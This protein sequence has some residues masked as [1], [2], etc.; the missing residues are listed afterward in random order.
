MSFMKFPPHSTEQHP[1]AMRR[2]GFTLIELLVVIAI[3]ALLIGLLLPAIQ[4]VRAAAARMSCSNNLKQLGLGLHNFETAT[5]ALPTAFPAN[6]PAPYET[7]PPYYHTW[8]SLAQILPYLEQTN[9]SN[10]LNLNLP[11]YNPADFTIFP[12]NRDAVGMKVRLFLC[13]ADREQSL[14]GGYGVT[15]FGTT[16]Y[17]ACL[18]SGVANGVAALGSPWDADGMFR[19]RDRVK[20]GEI[21]DGLSNTAAMSESTL[22]EG[23]DGVNGAMPADAWKVFAYVSIG[24]PLSESACAEAH[25]WNYT[26]R[27]GFM[28][29]SGEIR[30]ASYN[31]Y[32]RPNDATYDCVTNS[33]V[34]GPQ[35][36]TAIGF[37][38]ARS[39]HTGVVN[40]LFGD[41]SV[42]SIRDSITLETWRA[43]ATRGGKEVFSEE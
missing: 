11:M 13:P 5:G 29:A 23:A 19:A 40:V 22:G 27:R 12:E 10:G 43:M 3:I 9:L 15:E 38:A 14:G 31:H 16:N 21:T 17:V 20:L 2:R 1:V 35:A 42:R 24:T 26:K 18:G 4:K 6:P 37:R 30:S 39:A 32:L 8:S 7:S 33:L 28:W 36:L 41:G 25:R 34:G